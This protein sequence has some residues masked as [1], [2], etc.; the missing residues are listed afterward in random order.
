MWISIWWRKKLDK[1]VTKWKLNT[2]LLLNNGEK[3]RIIRKILRRSNKIISYLFER[4]E[5]V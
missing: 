4:N 2:Y 1:Y 5:I 3:R